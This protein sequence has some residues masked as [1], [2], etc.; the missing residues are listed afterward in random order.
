VRIAPGDTAVTPLDFVSYPWSHSLA[1]SVAWAAAIGLLSLAW[2]GDRNRGAVLALCFLSHWVLDALTHR[3]D[4][5]LAPGSEVRVG[6]GLWRSVPATVIV[7][8]LMYIAG[9]GIY[10]ASTRAR[11]A[12]GRWGLAALVLVLPVIYA[13]NVAGPP[14]PSVRAIEWAGIAGTVLFWSWAAWV[15]RH[16]EA[17]A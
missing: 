15:D 13:A 4:L 6:L 5:P 3:P 7:E 9:V 1:M 10:L 12:V 2:P 11:D 17:V 8:T 14:P 16:R